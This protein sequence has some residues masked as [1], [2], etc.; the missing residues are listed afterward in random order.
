MSAVRSGGAGLA[1]V[2]MALLHAPVPRR[3]L[4]S[5]HVPLALATVVMAVAG[6]V[7]AAL[8][9]AHGAPARVLFA[10][11]LALGAAVTTATVRR[12]QQVGVVV[13]VPLVY[14]VLLVLGGIAAHDGPLTYWLASAF[15]VKAPVV[16]IATVVA[17][18]VALV[19]SAI[20]H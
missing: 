10:A 4:V 13:A 11:F 2:D 17:L 15:I 19:R 14:L 16:L 12:E 18:A 8:D 6:I 3:P 20:R 1:S 9:T 7:G 5:V